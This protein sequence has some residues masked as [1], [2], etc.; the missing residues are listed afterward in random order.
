MS[1]EQVEIVRSLYALLDRGDDEAVRAL[2]HPDFA[3]DFSRRLLDPVVLRGFDEMRTWG[4][5]ERDM[6]EE[7]HVTWEPEELIDAGDKVL[8]LVRTGGRGKLSGA[9]V[10]AHVWNLWTFRD[11]RAVEWRYFG[12]DRAA[13]FEAA[14]LEEPD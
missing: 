4:D 10:D 6:W 8:A 7:G 14:G 11:G 9:Q 12:D 13:A 3:A 2:L 1:Q 5:R